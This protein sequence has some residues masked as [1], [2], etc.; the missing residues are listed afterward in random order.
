[1]IYNRNWYRG[2]LAMTNPHVTVL[3]PVYNAEA[4]LL[5]SVESILSQ[6]YTDFELLIINDASTD[7]SLG[8]I[9]SIKDPRIRLISNPKN[10][11]QTKSLNIGLKAAKGKYIAINDADDLSLP[12]R[13]KRQMD[14]LE[15]NPSVTVV[16]ASA[17]IMDQSG[18]I[19][20]RFIKSTDS[21]DIILCTLN[22]PPV[23]HGSIVMNKDT[24]LSATGGY[25]EDIRI[26]QDYALW[27]L[28]LR[29]GF[30]IANVPEPLVVIRY[31]MES[32]SFKEKDAQTLE[33]GTIIYNNVVFLTTVNISREDAVRQRMFFASPL[34][35]NWDNFIS[36]EELFVSEYNDLKQKSSYDQGY[37][38]RRLKSEL[39][40]PF[41]KRAIAEFK[42]G[43]RREAR[44]TARRYLGRYGF[45]F[46]PFMV[47][48]ASFFTIGVL[49]VMLSV[50]ERMQELSV[51]RQ[52]LR[53]R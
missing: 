41:A 14:F 30:K 52:A 43:K 27:S 7:G 42:D 18:S 35:L 8:I 40:K 31:Y 25:D 33:N 46:I 10:L 3:M 29:K 22:D 12:H 39:V 53:S 1:M 23:I 48:V 21:R 13:L 4:Y 32:I 47:W 24:V 5:E 34:K 20:R 16:G 44:I 45:S 37:L 19:K 2:E 38:A 50:H 36:A 17:Y 51:A 11:G 26:C 9:E 49:N 28:L 6:T 15:R